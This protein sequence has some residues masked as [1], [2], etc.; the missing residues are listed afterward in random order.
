MT[1]YL[2][3]E[4]TLPGINDATRA[5]FTSGRLKVQRCDDCRT[6]QH[7]PDEICG[8]CQGNRLSFAECGEAGRIESFVVVHRAVHP[9]LEDQIPYAVALV[10]LDDAPGVNAIGNVLNAAPDELAIGQRVRAV[11][12]E[13]SQPN[14]GEVLRIPQWELI[15]E[16]R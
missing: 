15:R 10:S 14:G 3:D 12:E 9:A 7:P 11:F 1:R 2:G 5:W 13:V 6:W 16:A 4:W 8:G